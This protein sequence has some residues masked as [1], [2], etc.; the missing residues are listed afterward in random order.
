MP[1]NGSGQ[2]TLPVQMVPNTLARAS[3]VNDDFNDIAVALTQ[4]ISRLGEGAM[5][6]PLKLVDGTLAAPALSF[7]NQPNTGIR[8]AA[9]NDLR[10]VVNG[11]DILQVTAT[12]LTVLSGTFNVLG[13]PEPG[14][15]GETA[16]SNAPTGWLLCY[17]QA[18]SRT[19]Y[20]ALFAKIGTTWG[21]GDGS[22]TFNVPDL[23]GCVT[24]GRD[25]MGGVAALRLTNSGVGN[26]DINGSVLGAI[27]G[28]DRIQITGA[29][30]PNHTHFA[31]VNDPGHSHGYIKPNN[32]VQPYTQVPGGASNS[33]D[34]AATASSGTGITVSIVPTGGNE[35]HPNVQPTAVVNKIIYTGVP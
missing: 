11:V 26:P 7:A 23:R 27:G 24:A 34:G 29:Q 6:A 31:V 28:R 9:N 33:G 12:G 3:D 35:F 13:L 2:Y 15:L 4:S 20:S 16:G 10:I 21:A 19:T 30:M 8:R 17:G 22:T 1:R 5:Q 14:M 25:N 32:T 18:I